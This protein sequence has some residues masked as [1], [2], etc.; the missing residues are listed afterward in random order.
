MASL[1]ANFREERRGGMRLICDNEWM[2]A[3]SQSKFFSPEHF[4]KLFF[5][6]RGIGRGTALQ[7]TLPGV[8]ERFFLRP[9]LHGGI[10]GSALGAAS[11]GLAR[12]LHEIAVTAALRN[13]G[14]PVPRPAFVLGRTFCGHAKSL[15][16]KAAL[17]SVAIENTVDGLAFFASTPDPLRIERA[18]RSAAK[19]IRKFHDCGGMHA[20]LQIKNMLISEKGSDTEVFL[21]DLDRARL[22]AHVSPA[23]R[24]QEL[25]RLYRSLIKRDLLHHFGRSIASQEKAAYGFLHA[26]TDGDSELETALLAHLAK[27]KLR[28]AIHRLGYRS[29][30]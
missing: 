28:V 6:D 4:E 1:P 30:K 19:A 25:M 17:A 15:L 8:N 29:P 24:M 26:Y 9:V 20:D 23:R 14:A 18:T 13:A 10:L 12:P 21:I 3:V 16:W 5:A 22:V 2:P 27:E 11:L 7:I